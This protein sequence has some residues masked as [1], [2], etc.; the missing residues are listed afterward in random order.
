MKSVVGW[1]EMRGGSELE[2]W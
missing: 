1:S 2:H